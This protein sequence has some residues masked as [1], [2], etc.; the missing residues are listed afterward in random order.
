[1]L[2]RASQFSNIPLG[3]VVTLLDMVTLSRAVHP[4]NIEFPRL[5]TLLGISTLVIPE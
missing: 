4:I 2:V 5:V 1:M 3:M